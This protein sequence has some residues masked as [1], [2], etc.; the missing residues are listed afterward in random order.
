MDIM[1]CHCHS[2]RQS[3]HY[4]T[5]ALALHHL[6]QLENRLKKD[7]VYSTHYNAFMNGIIRLDFVEWVPEKDLER[8]DSHIWYIPHHGVYH[9]K[10]PGKICVVFDCSAK[11]K[12]VSLND[13]LLQGLI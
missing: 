8:Q 11:Q 5:T 12:G 9:L 13:H 4:Q 1:R 10:K 7:E 2:E 3:L 6:K